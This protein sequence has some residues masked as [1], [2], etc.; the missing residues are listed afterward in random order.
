MGV[1]TSCSGSE[2]VASSSSSSRSSVNSGRGGTG[3]KEKLLELVSGVVNW[4][5]G[6]IKKGWSGSGKAAPL[7]E[8]LSIFLSVV[9]G[10]LEW[11]GSCTEASPERVVDAA[12]SC[13]LRCSF[14][15]A[16]A[17]YYR[18]RQYLLDHEPSQKRTDHTTDNNQ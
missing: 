13:L 12:S 10:S 9:D 14:L 8:I 3:V 6:E 11:A 7:R 15:L 17:L 18:E 16:T 5:R 2:S 4:G 1:A